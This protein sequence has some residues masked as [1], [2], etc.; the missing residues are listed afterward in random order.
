MESKPLLESKV[1]PSSQKQSV[2]FK[3]QIWS[4]GAIEGFGGHCQ[5]TASFH[6]HRWKHWQLF[7][8]SDLWL[9]CAI[10]TAFVLRFLIMLL[11]LILNNRLEYRHVF[12]GMS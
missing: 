2:K 7:K 6:H 10:S 1:K 8:H 11:P 5:V 9:F 12:L 4:I 3:L